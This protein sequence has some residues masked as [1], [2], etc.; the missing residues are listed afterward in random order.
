M[1]GIDSFTISIQSNSPRHM[2]NTSTREIIE[3]ICQ[4]TKQTRKKLRTWKSLLQFLTLRRSKISLYQLPLLGVN[5]PRSQFMLTL[6]AKILTIHYQ[7]T[8]SQL[9]RQQRVSYSSIVKN[10]M[11]SLPTPWLK[12]KKVSKLSSTTISSNSNLTS[13]LEMYMLWVVKL[14]WIQAEEFQFK[15]PKGIN[16]VAISIPLWPRIRRTRTR[17]RERL[18]TQE[19]KLPPQ[20]YPRAPSARKVYRSGKK[21]QTLKKAREACCSLGIVICSQ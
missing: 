14:K 10:P 3:L 6:T 2:H 21:S 5:N 4:L 7:Q 12:I 1:T 8:F 16:I 20:L 15:T 19:W 9:Y 11:S 17:Y 18:C 13:C